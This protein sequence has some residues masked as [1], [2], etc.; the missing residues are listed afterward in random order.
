MDKP[1][2]ALKDDLDMLAE[3]VQQLYIGFTHLDW[4]VQRIKRLDEELT[5]QGEQMRRMDEYMQ[6]TTERMQRMEKQ[7]GLMGTEIAKISGLETKISGLETKISRLEINIG[8]IMTH[9]KI[10]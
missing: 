4:I 10:K 2:F 7:M 9:L 6:I 1:L 5:C 8:K 3:K